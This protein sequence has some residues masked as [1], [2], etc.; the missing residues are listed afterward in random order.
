MLKARFGAE[1]KR[2]ILAL[3]IFLATAT[4]AV[5]LNSTVGGYGWHLNWSISRYVGL[6]LWSVMLFAI[7]NCFVA[8]LMG[9]YLWRL[10]ERWKMSKIYFV[11]VLVM[12]AALL[13]LSFCPIGFCDVGDMRST[14]SLM[15]EFSSRTMF[16]TMM[17]IAATIVICRRAGRLAHA[18]NV[19]Y[20]VY[21]SFC[22]VGQLTRAEWFAPMVLVYESVYLIGFLL[23]MAYCGASAR[24]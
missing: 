15:H 14:V 16:I 17:L 9:S 18:L 12:A 22:V 20:R 4:L 6:E 21:A 24:R 1:S 10:G 5:V 7:G 3:M 23:I 2:M 8:A 11:L 19:G 13:W